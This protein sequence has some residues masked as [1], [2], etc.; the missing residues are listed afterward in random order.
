MV[1]L[2]ICIARGPSGS[3]NDN[4]EFSAS[5]HVISLGHLPQEDVGI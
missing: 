5:D 2:F 3:A 4:V 1:Y